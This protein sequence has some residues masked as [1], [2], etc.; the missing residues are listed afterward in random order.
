MK[1]ETSLKIY[2]AIII[3]CLITLFIIS[4]YSLLN[5]RKIKQENALLKQII[6]EDL[7]IL[8]TDNVKTRIRFLDAIGLYLDFSKLFVNSLDEIIDRNYNNKTL[9]KAKTYKTFLPVLEKI[10]T[11]NATAKKLMEENAYVK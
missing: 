9:N 3:A 5:A 2:S 11:F 10:G 6:S 4:A 8:K 7:L 1:K